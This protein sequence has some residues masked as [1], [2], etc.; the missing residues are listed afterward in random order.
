MDCPIL[1]F[2]CGLVR[3]WLLIITTGPSDLFAAYP[4]VGDDTPVP[5]PPEGA[6]IGVLQAVIDEA[7]G[8]G[9]T[10]T[11]GDTARLAIVA[12]LHLYLKKNYP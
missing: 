6:V 10:P 5:G 8:D 9:P 1:S 11:A 2:P 3:V 4:A 7:V 12:F